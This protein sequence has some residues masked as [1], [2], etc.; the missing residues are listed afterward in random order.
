MLH[1]ILDHALKRLPIAQLLIRPLRPVI[2]RLLGGGLHPIQ[3]RDM[4]PQLLEGHAI[5][6]LVRHG[7]QLARVVQIQIRRG[8]R[9]LPPL[10]A[11]LG[12]FA[13]RVKRGAGGVAVAVLQARDGAHGGGV[14]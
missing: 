3:L 1:Q 12:G 4:V 5:Q 8:R 6:G 10:P 13:L 14:G 9:A 7:A 2:Q 11:G